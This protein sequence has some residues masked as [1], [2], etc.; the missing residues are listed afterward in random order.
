M[1]LPK[2]WPLSS[3]NSSP[4]ENVSSTLVSHSKF[5]MDH[6]QYL[7]PSN[8]SDLNHPASD[9][10]LTFPLTSIRTPTPSTLCYHN[11][12]LPPPFFF[13]SPAPNISSLLSLQA[14]IPCSIII[15]PLPLPLNCCTLLA[16]PKL[17]LWLNA[18]LSPTLVPVLMNLNVAARRQHTA[19]AGR[20]FTRRHRKSC[21]TLPCSHTISLSVISRSPSSYGTSSSLSSH[22]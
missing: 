16:K 3:L 12:L 8:T 10:H 11:P 7:T 13:L 2:L 15:I 22:L 1:I 18:T 14:S 20:P 4:P 17:Q 6:H 21:S 5:Q 19:F 9:N